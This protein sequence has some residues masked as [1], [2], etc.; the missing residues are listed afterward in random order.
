MARIREVDALLKEQEVKYPKIVSYIDV[1][2]HLCI[3]GN[4]YCSMFDGDTILYRDDDHLSVAGSK[5]IVR[6]YLREEL[7][8]SL[9]K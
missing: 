1:A 6:K 7:A 2:K 5:L 8:S 4:E 9:S 3:E